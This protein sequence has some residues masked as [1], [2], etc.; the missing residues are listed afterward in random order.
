MFGAINGHIH[1]LLH[2][3]SYLEYTRGKSLRSI[4]I[5][6]TYRKQSFF[7]YFARIL[8]QGGHDTKFVDFLLNLFCWQAGKETK[9]VL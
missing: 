3:F 5:R 6:I 1:I 9:Y 8:Q 2:S 4:R 7:S